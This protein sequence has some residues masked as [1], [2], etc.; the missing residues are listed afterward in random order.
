[1]YGFDK[2]SFAIGAAFLAALLTMLFWGPIRDLQAGSHSGKPAA[3][4][5]ESAVPPA[6]TFGSKAVLESCWSREALAGSPDSAKVVRPWNDPSRDDP[7]SR[8]APK[9]MLPPLAAP[10]RNSIRGVKLPAD[11]KFIALTFDLCERAHARAGYDARVVN[12][13][14]AHS[15]KATFFAG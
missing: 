14:R 5:T 9:T 11:K 1:M 4:P 7:P 15:I 8:L 2:K 3:P 13:L 12:Y 10:L 6:P